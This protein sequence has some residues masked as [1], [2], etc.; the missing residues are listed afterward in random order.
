MS[1]LW[2]DAVR[3]SLAYLA[4]GLALGWVLGMGMVASAGADEFQPS[5]IQ[6]PEGYTVELAAAPPLV[7]HPMMADFDDQGRLYVAASAG[8]NLRREDL[9][10]QLPNFVQRLEDTDG[11]GV[12]DKA[13]MFADKMTFPQGCMWLDGSLFVASSG[14][15]WKLTDTNDDGVADERVKL[16][17]DFGY[18]GNAADVHGPFRGPEGR[19]YWCEG[20]HGHEIRDAEGNLISQGKA[21]RVFSCRPDGS[22]VRTFATGGMDNPVEVVFTPE[23]DMLGSV[24]LMYSQPR[25]DTLVHWQYGG[26]YPR[27]DF[28][29]SLGHEFV[30]TGPLL[31]EIHNFGHIAISGLC[32][33]D[34][35]QW[36]VVND[37]AIFITQFNTNRVSRALLKPQGTSYAVKQVEDFAVSTNKDFHPTDVLQAPDGSLLVIDTGGWFRIGCPQSGVAKTH[38]PGAIYRIR[39]PDTSEQSAKVA[40][41]TRT[42]K[43]I[44]KVWQ[45]RRQETSQ[46]LAEL[47]KLLHSKEPRVRQ[48]AARALLDLPPSA[49]RDQLASKLVEV[50]TQGTPAERRNAIATLSHWRHHD[51]QFVRALLEMLPEV[52]DDANLRHAVMLGLI[53]GDRRDELRQAALDARPAVAQGAALALEEIARMSQP[54]AESP[55]LEIPAPSL[56]QP[57]TSQQEQSL[58]AIEA[59][60]PPGDATRGRQ[61]FFSEQSTCS[62]CHR[63]AGEGGQVGP[64]LSTIGRSRAHR[65]LLESILYPNATFARG[66]APYLIATDDGKTYAGIILAEE[67]ETLHLGID[68]KNAAKIPNAAIE[69]IRPSETSVMPADLHKTLPPEQ[70][71]DLLAYLLSLPQDEQPRDK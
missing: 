25:G 22:D 11:D 8:E 21:A 45:L 27:E 67:A 43:L 65:D 60:L 71:A 28:V 48:T 69:E 63:V 46:S 42:D 59:S 5:P 32:R 37:G 26:V 18:T 66:F 55:W 52:Q 68:Q 40:T 51:P 14:A 49:A 41:R 23:G 70:L 39:R 33:Y 2:R 12:F 53:R 4:L 44:R 56:G 47:G 6:V 57:L 31:P 62:K 24:N 38:I 17:G 10:K 3:Q 36:G 19:I 54:R 58:L 29:E 15:I 50:A 34:G 1:T 20:R 7:G 64:D 16:V 35:S 61:V 9:E 30:R 13:T